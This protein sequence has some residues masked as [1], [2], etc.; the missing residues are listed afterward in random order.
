LTKQISHLISFRTEGAKYKAAKSWGLHIVSI[1]WLRDSLER[2]MILDEKLYDPALPAEE[3][4]K[5]AWDRTKPKRT[6]LGKR[7]RG[8]SVVNLEGGKRKLR[9]M[10][11]TKLGSQSESMWGDIVGGASFAQVA[12]SGVWESNDAQAPAPKEPI[13]RKK[14][15]QDSTTKTLEGT[16]DSIQGIF[17]GCR[18]YLDGFDLKK[19]EIL[20]SHL[21]PHGAQVATTLK[22]LL[23]PAQNDPPVHSFRVI[24]SNLPAS[25]RFDL[26]NSDVQFETITEWWVE[27]CLHHKRFMDPADHVIGRPFPKYPIDEFREMT[28][29]S[30]AFTGIDLLHVKRAVDLLGGVYSEDMTPKSSVLITQSIEKLRKDKL[31]HA[32]QWGIP[33]VTAAWLWESIAAGKL[34]PLQKY[35]CRSSKRTESLPPNRVA[36]P[37]GNPR[38][39][40]SKS[41]IAT[42]ISKSDSVSSGSVAKLGD[43]KL[44]TTA[45]TASEPAASK[46]EGNPQSVQT[47]ADESNW[48]TDFSTATE[49]LS[50]INNNTCASAVSTAPA[51]LNHP[52]PQADINNAISNLLAKTK[53]SA[54]P[55]DETESAEGRR[56]GANR[57]LGRATS[58][59]S[60]ASRSLSRASSVDSTATHGRPVEYPPYSNGPG[61]REV[62]E[63][64]NDEVR[65]FANAST[66]RNMES[67]TDSPPPATQLQYDDPESKEYQKR[68]MAKMMGEKFQRADGPRTR[69][70]EKSITLGDVADATVGARQRGRTKRDKA[71]PGFK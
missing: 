31:D 48:T 3:R 8:D 30:A 53:S 61:K 26:P 36:G 2:G 54:K 7:S 38:H 63:T 42:P 22:E 29:S 1:E 52:A 69:L 55:L 65:K 46:G 16:T 5:G 23:A 56:R 32:Q 33:I 43:S 70:K 47:E 41:E 57:I 14:S 34:L 17:S 40:R 19:S 13:A 28:I 37:K 4:G 67:N 6:S 62:S 35:L 27:R 60:T 71:A 10:A 59:I 68:A 18:F 39:G 51:P 58:N 66:D 24:P 11:S 20:T 21:N 49:P 64:A 44:D 50:E 12:R 15:D 9:R 25:K 45:F